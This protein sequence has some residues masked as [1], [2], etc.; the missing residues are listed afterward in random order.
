MKWIDSS[1]GQSQTMSRMAI[2]M[3]LPESHSI[4]PFI[5]I[6]L[7]PPPRSLQVRH[8]TACDDR[9]RPEQQCDS[10]QEAHSPAVSASVFRGLAHPQ[11]QNDR[12]DDEPELDVKDRLRRPL[13]RFGR[14]QNEPARQIDREP[15]PENA[16][17]V[18]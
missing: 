2:A 1:A 7:S 18:A 6:L 10:G 9:A 5:V 11:G 8:E 17:E 15:H 13:A 4:E 14:E 3:E 12:R 16:N